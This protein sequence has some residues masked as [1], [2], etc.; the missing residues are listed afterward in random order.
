MISLINANPPGTELAEVEPSCRNLT[1]TLAS[2][3]GSEG[4][5]LQR[6]PGKEGVAEQSRTGRLYLGQCG[7]CVLCSNTHALHDEL[8]ALFIMQS[9]FP[10][11]YV[12]RSRAV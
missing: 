4:F 3:I 8:C 5:L 6:L 12:F 9:C 2:A 11:T 7:T 1:H 10:S